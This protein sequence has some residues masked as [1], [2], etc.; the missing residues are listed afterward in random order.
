MDTSSKAGTAYIS[1]GAGFIPAL[2]VSSIATAWTALVTAVAFDSGLNDVI[3]IFGTGFL[4]NVAVETSTYSFVALLVHSFAVLTF[5]SLSWQT[6]A[7]VYALAGG[8]VGA[9]F[10]WVQIS[11]SGVT[12]TDLGAPGLQVI[13][14]S[15]AL[16]ALSIYAI[17]GLLLYV[18]RRLWVKAER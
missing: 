3:Q 1:I 16:T 5:P 14:I 15:G 7:A 10:L 11:W 2:F 17:Y 4:M 6:R 13:V 12:F 9:S 18:V 8:L